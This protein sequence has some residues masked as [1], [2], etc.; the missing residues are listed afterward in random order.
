MCPRSGSH[1]IGEEI[2]FTFSLLDEFQE[3]CPV[4]CDNELQQDK[5]LVEKSASDAAENSFNLNSVFMS[6]HTNILE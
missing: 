2:F 3:L 4:P 5:N 6:I 1:T